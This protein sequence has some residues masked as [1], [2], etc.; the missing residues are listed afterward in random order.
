[1]TVD[2]PLY[3][4][5]PA[6]ARRPT[7]RQLLSAS[8]A[9]LRQDREL[10]WLP[11]I[12]AVASLA[13]AGILFVPG[14]FLG[15]VLGGSTHPSWAGWL[16]GVLAALGASVAAIYFQAALVF[17]AYE[18][19]DGGDPTLS[20]A[21]SAAWARRGRIVEWALLA[22]TVGTVIRGV[23]RRLGPLGAVAGW[24][25]GLA[26]AVATFLVVPVLVAEDL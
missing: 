14:W 17:G 3:A 12:G 23:E 15:D 24:L 21:L 9:M 4:T 13:C 19:A 11:A 6:L 1:M 5:P 2:Q 20:S 26:W 7:G 8:W 10:L 16:G 18:R 22:T 25:T